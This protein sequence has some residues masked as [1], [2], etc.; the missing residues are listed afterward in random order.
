MVAG[1]QNLA[2][3]RGHY[4]QS[5]ERSFAAGPAARPVD[6]NTLNQCAVV[7]PQHFQLGV[8]GQVERPEHGEY[9]SRPRPEGVGWIDWPDIFVKC[10]RELYPGEGRLAGIDTESLR[11]QDRLGRAYDDTPITTPKTAPDPG[12]HKMVFA[13]AV[14]NVLEG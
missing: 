7:C 3:L 10:R 2:W 12:A 1:Q 6:F 8:G 5:A 13:F 11:S 14:A 9:R 4:D